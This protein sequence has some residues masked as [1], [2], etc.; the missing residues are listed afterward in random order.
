MLPKL[1]WKG[2]GGE[3]ISKDLNNFPE[4]LDAPV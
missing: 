3:P 4:I 2:G 1:E